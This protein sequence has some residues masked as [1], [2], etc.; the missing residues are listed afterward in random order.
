M[1]NEIKV[2]L[3]LVV[4]LA[5]LAWLTIAS[6]TLGFGHNVPMREL[7]AVFED[8]QGIKE[9]SSVKMA[10]VDIGQVSRVELQPNGTAILRFKVR[11]SVALPADVSAQITAAGLIGERYVA[12][13]P[14]AQGRH[15]DGGLLAESVQQLPAAATV[16]PAN[17]GTNFAKMAEQM[18]GMTSNLQTV[19]GDPENAR[20]LQGMIDALAKFSDSMN[21]SGGMDSAMKN[22]NVATGNFAKISQDLRSGKGTIGQLLADDPSG[23]KVN[24]AQTL[25]QMN[26]AIA[27]FRQIMEKI[28][29]GQG[30]LGRLVNDS[31]TADKLDSTLDS[32]NGLA[33]GIH[34]FL[35]GSSGRNASSAVDVS[36]TDSEPAKHSFLRAEGSLE[37]VGVLGEDNVFKGN[38]NARLQAGG[39][40]VD[41]GVQGD[42]FAS[43]AK[44]SDNIGGPYY[45][46]DFGSTVK[47][48]AQVG[49]MFDGAL[50]GNDVALRAGLKN[51][52]AGVGTDIYGRMPFT[53]KGVRYSADLYDFGGANTPG[54]D[55]HLDLTARAD[56][57]RRI[58][59]IVG[60]D[61]V[62]SD[63]YGG[64]MVG[65]GIRFQTDD[66]KKTYT[67]GKNL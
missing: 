25:A 59:G 46:K 67:S 41:L 29:S 30:T 44:G 53:D 21:G 2:G 10:G 63:Q 66:G 16:D 12:L 8:V 34:G 43:K 58:Y 11:K 7:F 24:L 6:G 60:Y 49:Q 37:S 64:P 42:G 55:A 9:G 33:G 45:G 20:K 39:K 27:D 48:T 14:G 19:L 38:A 31:S 32:V 22:L 23:S 18:Q 62:L 40:F 5:V 35:G 1:S 36:G 65:L 50:L 56:L 51:S 26:A 4:A 54:D 47:Y 17:V 52:T 15:G 3:L 57:T 13:V 28:N 61:N